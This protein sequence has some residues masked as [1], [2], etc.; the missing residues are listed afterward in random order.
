MTSKRSQFY[1]IIAEKFRA[2]LTLYWETKMGLGV[3]LDSA[4]VANLPQ[5]EIVH[6]NLW[7]NNSRKT[8]NHLLDFLS[9]EHISVTLTDIIFANEHNPLLTFSLVL[10][11][12]GA[13]SPWCIAE[14]TIQATSDEVSLEGVR[15]EQNTHEELG[16]NNLENDGT[17]ITP[18][19]N[20][21]LWDYYGETL[22]AGY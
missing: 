3:F 16:Q 15:C 21:S 6:L 22:L 19:D 8:I 5:R 1:E 7:M 10:G 9:T 12:D 14:I 13:K 18:D 2:R 20:D 11:D 17:F 4:L